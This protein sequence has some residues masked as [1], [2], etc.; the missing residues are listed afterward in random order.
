MKKVFLTAILAIGSTFATT[1]NAQTNISFGVKLNGNLTNVKV[2]NLQNESSSFKPGA[3][4]GSFA[5][6]EFGD[7]FALQPELLLN[8]TERKINMV[9][10]KTKFK[11]ISVEIPV[12]L[13]GQ[14]NVRNGKLFAGIGPNIGYGFSIDSNMENLSDCDK[15]ANKLELSHWYM[16]AG[17][18][19]G[20]EFHNGISIN[21]E[22]KLG[23]DLSSKNKTSGADT[24]TISLGVGYRF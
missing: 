17:A 19:I 4:L 23:Y 14:L 6:M 2:S 3:S 21:A 1:V 15:K 12:Y 9:G 20:Y 7:H 10:E 8:Y 16:G 5:K 11:Y 13:M 22:Y 18:L 24:Q